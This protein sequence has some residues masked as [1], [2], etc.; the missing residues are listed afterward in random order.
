MRIMQKKPAWCEAD[1]S[2]WNEM[3]WTAKKRPWNN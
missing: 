2:Y 1:V 3:G